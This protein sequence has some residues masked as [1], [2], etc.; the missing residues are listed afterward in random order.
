M[1]G[2]PPLLG[3]DSLVT[4]P[5]KQ[6]FSRLRQGLS[7]GGSATGSRS[8]TI[9]NNIRPT[10]VPK[11]TFVTLPG[12]VRFRKATNY[13]V[14]D[15]VLEPKTGQLT[16]GYVNKPG[17]LYHGR[18]AL[19]KTS[20]AGYNDDE[21]FLPNYGKTDDPALPLI[22]AQNVIPTS[23]R[24]EAVTKALNKL[25]DQKVNLGENLATLQQTMSLLTHPSGSLWK[26]LKSLHEV[27]K[28]ESFKRF[29]Y[30]TAREISRAS[31]VDT[32]AQEYLKYVYGWKPLMQDVH[33]LIELSKQSASRD[34]LVH[35]TGTSKYSGSRAGVTNSKSVST[36]TVY[37]TGPYQVDNVVRC[38]L[39]G[40]IDPNYTGTRALNQLGLLNPAS[41]AWELVP[42]SFVVDWVIPI[43]PVLNALT[44]PAGLAFV[45]GTVSGRVSATGPYSSY[46]DNVFFGRPAKVSAD[47]PA[48]GTVR[49]NGY[50][51]QVL[52]G[53]PLPGLWF[54]SDP[55]R[56][57]RIFK[58]LALSLLSLRSKRVNGQKY[59]TPR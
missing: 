52:T 21:L 15:Y 25:A 44:A 17:D 56:N 45:D 16:E 28:K 51:R 48:S 59:H 14:R 20:P 4:T 40:R 29:L 31:P 12:G 18:Y 5:T 19:Y 30:K 55:L 7:T 35:S 6:T 42:W 54:D 32:V 11:G 22:Y 33:G 49:Y 24:N 10:P 2:N 37:N 53:W 38:S 13:S 39:W 36:D 9:G 26:L 50:T 34:L 3:V 41:L 8:V 1:R 47:T 27:Y 57:D 43:G 46:Y 58:A 23:N